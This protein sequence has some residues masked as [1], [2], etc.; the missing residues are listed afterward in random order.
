VSY[1]EAQ[2]FCHCCGERT[3]TRAGV[4][5]LIALD[6]AKEKALDTGE[7]AKAAD[8]SKRNVRRLVILWGELFAYGP[9]RGNW[10]TYRLSYSLYI[11]CALCSEQSPAV[12]NDGNGDPEDRCIEWCVDEG[13][14]L[15]PQVKPI[16]EGSRRIRRECWVCAE[17]AREVRV[18]GA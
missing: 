10:N 18:Q 1:S 2:R 16:K 6:E 4:R 15:L 14:V 12:H 7:L 8:T 17:C 13:W 5:A 3:L 11:A 9:K